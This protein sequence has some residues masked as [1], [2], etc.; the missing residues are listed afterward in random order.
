MNPT[1]LLIL[2]CILIIALSFAG[3]GIKMFLKKDGKF[4]KKCGSTDPKTG[5][6]IGCSC[7]KEE[8]C[9]NE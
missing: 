1:L 6:K 3:I 5:E 2:T 8:S 4:E 9:N 7:K